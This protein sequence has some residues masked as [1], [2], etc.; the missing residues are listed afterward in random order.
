MTFYEFAHKLFGAQFKLMGWQVRGA[1]NL[2]KEGPV[3]VAINHVSLWDPLL[4]GCGLDRQVW[5]MAK[6]E[7][8]AIPVL[9]WVIKQWGAFPVKR[10]KGDT[11]A[12]RQSLAVLKDGRVLGV[13]PEGT[14]SKTGEMQKGLPGIV[15]LMEKTQAPIVPIKVYGTK[16]LLTKGW[17]KLGMVVG[18][19]LMPEM[20]KAPEGVEDRREWVANRIMEELSNLE[21]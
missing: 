15:L 18:K 8:F 4:V 14:R 16:H 11:S 1:E 5:Y 6:E 19:P 10:G 7:L 21:S 12:I 17:G 9:G 2:P 3:I 13:F 20:L